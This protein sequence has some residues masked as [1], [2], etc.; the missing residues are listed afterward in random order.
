MQSGWPYDIG[1]ASSSSPLII[2]LNNDGNKEIVFGDY[3]G[4]VHAVNI[5]GSGEITGFPTD[6]LGGNIS[7][8]VAVSNIS[9]DAEK[10]IVFGNAG[11]NAW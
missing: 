2:D 5:D 10:E 7:S 9:G 11:N 8:A 4:I 3:V 1:G 6:D